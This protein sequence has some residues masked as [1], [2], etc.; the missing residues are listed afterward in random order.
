VTPDHENYQAEHAKNGSQPL[1]MGCPVASNGT[2]PCGG[3]C[4]PAT[5]K[6]I[7]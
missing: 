2:V 4:A 5:T 1:S 3:G 7:E 6:M